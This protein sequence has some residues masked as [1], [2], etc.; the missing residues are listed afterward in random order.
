MRTKIKM[1]CV[2]VKFKLNGKQFNHRSQRII[3]KDF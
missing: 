2:V 1:I 3:L